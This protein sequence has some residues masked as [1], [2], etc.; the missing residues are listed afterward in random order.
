M[1]L[2]QRLM[3]FLSLRAAERRAI[4]LHVES[5]PKRY[6][7]RHTGFTLLE[8]MISVGIIAI[9][10]AVAVPQYLALVARAAASEGLSIGGGAASSIAEAYQNSGG[11]GAQFDASIA[12][13]NA[14]YAAQTP[15]SKYVSALT[16]ANSAA[17]WPGEILITYS[18]NA[19]GPIQGT[20][21]ELTP[22][23]T[24]SNGFQALGNSSGNPS[25]PV[26]WGCSGAGDTVVTALGM[27]NHTDGTLPVIYSPS[28][29]K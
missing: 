6:R 17:T 26:D 27:R 23:Q 25:M 7:L 12:N 9:L 22:E 13:L 14:A 5:L 21:L 28:T 8:L 15:I 10:I 1:F 4:V 20:V 18:A 11:I 29:C 3:N 24:G 19:P 2:L 16:I